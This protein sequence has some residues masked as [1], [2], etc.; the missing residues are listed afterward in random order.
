VETKFDP[1]QLVIWAEVLLPPFPPNPTPPVMNQW[2]CPSDTHCWNW[3]SVGD[4]SVPLNPP[5]GMTGSSVAS[6]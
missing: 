1:T 2:I 6:W 4:G 5:I 3:A